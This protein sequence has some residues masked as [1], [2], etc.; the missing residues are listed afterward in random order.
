MRF[1]HKQSD[2]VCEVQLV[3]VEDLC[4]GKGVKVSGMT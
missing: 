1:W 4:G 2:D 3:G